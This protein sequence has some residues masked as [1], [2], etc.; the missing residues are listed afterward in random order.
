FKS[1]CRKL[2][3]PAKLLFNIFAKSAR[4]N[5]LSSKTSFRIAVREST[6][7]ANPVIMKQKNLYL[8]PPFEY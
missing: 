5:A 3:C 7:L 1:I 2:S 8:A 6:V 4:V